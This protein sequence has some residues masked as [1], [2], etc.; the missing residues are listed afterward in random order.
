MCK[1]LLVAEQETG[2]ICFL[3]LSNLKVSIIW[4]HKWLVDGKIRTLIR[5]TQTRQSGS[6][7]VRLDEHLIVGGKEGW[8]NIWVTNICQGAFCI[9]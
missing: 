8:T 7:Y 2:R 9:F 5:A 3:H 4:K 1:S 6:Y